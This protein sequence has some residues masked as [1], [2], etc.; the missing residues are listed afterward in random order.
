MMM[1]SVSVI[2]V[3]GSTVIVVIEVGPMIGVLAGKRE[4]SCYQKATVM[5]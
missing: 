2:S 3:G 5:G 1:A 4:R